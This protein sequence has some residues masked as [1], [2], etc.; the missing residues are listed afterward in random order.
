MK[1]HIATLLL[2]MLLCTIAHINVKAKGLSFHPIEHAS[3]IIEHN[4]LTIYVD[5]VGD[6]DKYKIFSKPDIILITHTHGDH[7]NKD[8][9]E[10]I[11]SEKTT[12]VGNEKSIETLGYGKK[13]LNNE[14]A[15][16]GNIIIE[17]IPMYNTTPERINFHQRG[18]G[19]GYVLTI[20]NERVYISGDTEDIME[21]RA[22]ENI[23]HAFLCM[24]LPY[25]MTVGQAASA[26]L[27]FKPKYAYPY[28]YRERNGKADINKFK[29]LVE[30]GGNTKVTFLKWYNE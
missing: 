19:N 28:H 5:P 6:I 27:E 21:M 15:E 7:F 17:A 8:L 20:D 26:T 10:A 13:M 12:I 14:I 3:F 18:D 30:A 23:D 16:L 4:N 25:T 24:N 1:T 9:I 11:K 2:I 29:D 22:L